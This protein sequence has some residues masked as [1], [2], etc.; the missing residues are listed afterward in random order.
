MINRLSAVHPD[1]PH[2]AHAVVLCKQAHQVVIQ[3]EKKAGLPR[4]SLASGTAA[5]LIID[6][7]GFVPLRTQNVKAPK[8][9][10]FV[11]VF[12]PGLVLFFICCTELLMGRFSAHFSAGPEI[13][14][15]PEL[16]IGTASGHIGCNSNRAL[17]SSLRNN[18]SLTG[19]VFGVEYLVLNSFFL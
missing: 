10:D 6:S 2:K 8:L 16:Y 4:V 11:V 5:Q 7:P 13:G 19:V 17:G 9:F 12:Y 1:S 18:Q 15:T 14:V 3:G